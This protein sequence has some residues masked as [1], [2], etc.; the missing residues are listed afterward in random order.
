VQEAATIQGNDRILAANGKR[1]ETWNS[2]Q[3]P[4]PNTNYAMLYGPENKAVQ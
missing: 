4:L 3:I 2:K 1:R